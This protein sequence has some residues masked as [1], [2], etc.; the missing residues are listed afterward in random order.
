[1]LRALDTVEDDMTI[2]TEEKVSMLKSFYTHLEEPGWCY[3]GCKDKD[4]IV[5]E[6]FS[7]VID[8]NKVQPHDRTPL[9]MFCRCLLNIVNLMR[10][11][12]L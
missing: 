3:M 12:V 11:I 8:C 5:L 4:K 6:N 2:P 10:Y 9:F 1:M 7:T